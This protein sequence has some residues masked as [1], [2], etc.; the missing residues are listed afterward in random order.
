MNVVEHGNVVDLDY[1]P[2]LERRY[3]LF[4]NETVRPNGG[5]QDL[6]G[7]F[8][9]LEDAL[10]YLAEFKFFRNGSF[11]ILD[12]VEKKIVDEGHFRRQIGE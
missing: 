4:V 1:L 2:D 10:S 6:G 5:L 12:S 3:W 9:T 7:T 8:H 11:H